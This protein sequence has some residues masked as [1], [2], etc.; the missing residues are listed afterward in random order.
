M[1]LDPTKLLVIGVVALVVL[2]PDQLPRLGRTAGLLWHEFQR[3]RA[4][5]D[6]HVRNAFPDLPAAHEIAAAV[7]SPVALLDRLASVAG[8]PAP[9]SEGDLGA[10]APAPGSKATDTTESVPPGP[11]HTQAP[12]ETASPPEAPVDYPAA[13]TT[14]SPDDSSFAS[15]PG[16]EAAAAG[17]GEL[18]AADAASMN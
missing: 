17:S 3:L 4:G 10:H 14:A 5:L 16:T 18:G 15:A 8:A 11:L 13:P 12:S 1:F 9:G 7:R 2:G 6:D